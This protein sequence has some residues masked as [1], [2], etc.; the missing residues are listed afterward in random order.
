MTKWLND[1]LTKWLNVYKTKM[2]NS[3]MTLLSFQEDPKTGLT[4]EVSAWPVEE[5]TWYLGAEVKRSPPHHLNITFIPKNGTGRSKESPLFG[6]ILSFSSQELYVK[7]IAALLVAEFDKDLHQG[8]S[9]ALVNDRWCF[10]FLYTYNT[11]LV[12]WL[13]KLLW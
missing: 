8:S 3:W 1:W 13:L 9:Q 11:H 2:T 4:S 7:W 10:Y 5:Q 6:R 12:I